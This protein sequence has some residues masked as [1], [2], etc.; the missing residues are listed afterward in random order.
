MLTRF[1]LLFKRYPKV[2]TALGTAAVGAA[3]LYGGPAGAKAAG[4]L[5]GWI[6]G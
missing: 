4:E 3:G 1:K 6:F 5:L 2:S